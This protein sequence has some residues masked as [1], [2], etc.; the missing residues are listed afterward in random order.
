MSLTGPRKGSGVEG[1]ESGR[2]EG[3]GDARGEKSEV[4][5]RLV[6]RSGSRGRGG[7][8]ASLWKAEAEANDGQKSLSLAKK[9]EMEDRLTREVLDTVEVAERGTR[10]LVMLEEKGS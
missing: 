9:L 4:E 1:R 5:R 2:G 10:V 6:S 7:V 3:K 8:G